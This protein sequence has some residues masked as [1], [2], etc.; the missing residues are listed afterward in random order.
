MF[1]L[2]C[3]SVISFCN[4]L[5]LYRQALLQQIWQTERVRTSLGYVTT[6][7]IDPRRLTYLQTNVCTDHWSYKHTVQ[8]FF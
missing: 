5:A 6:E 4:W 8:T 2:Q 3:K 1:K 7:R